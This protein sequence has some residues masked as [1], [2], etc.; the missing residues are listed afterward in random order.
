MQE[1]QVFLQ[2]GMIPRCKLMKLRRYWKSDNK[3]V[4]RNFQRADE[5]RAQLTAAGIEILMASRAAVGDEASFWLR[6][7][8]FYFP[9][10]KQSSAKIFRTIKIIFITGVVM[11]KLTEL[12]LVQIYVKAIF[13]VK[14]P[15]TYSKVYENQRALEEGMVG[16]GSNQGDILKRSR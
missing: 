15:T 12:G 7:S 14:H 8:Y 10:F 4:L 1:P 3:R 6:L 9:E 16:A 2:Q 13:L 5:I 11:A